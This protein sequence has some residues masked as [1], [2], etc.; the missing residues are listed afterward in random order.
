[1]VHEKSHW[2]WLYTADKKMNFDGTPAEGLP[3]SLKWNRST[4]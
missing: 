4:L 1:M 2:L 3:N